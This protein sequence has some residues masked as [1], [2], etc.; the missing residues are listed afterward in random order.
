MLDLPLLYGANFLL[1]VW[2]VIIVLPKKT[3]T[4]CSAY[5]AG[6]FPKWGS[7]LSIWIIFCS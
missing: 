7:T 2:K 6:I 1:C 5:L 4:K 3:K